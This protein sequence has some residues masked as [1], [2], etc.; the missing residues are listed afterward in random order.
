MGMN[1]SD[2]SFEE[3]LIKKGNFQTDSKYVTILDRMGFYLIHVTYTMRQIL[4]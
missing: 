1:N 2:D 4:W 3:I